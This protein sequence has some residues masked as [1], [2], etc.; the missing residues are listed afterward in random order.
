MI[1]DLVTNFCGEDKC[2]YIKL[3]FFAS[4]HFCEGFIV[5][6]LSNFECSLKGNKMFIHRDNVCLRIFLTNGPILLG[7]DNFHVLY[8]IK[9]FK[10]LWM[11]SKMKHKFSLNLIGKKK[12]FLVCN[13]SW[14]PYVFGDQPSYPN[15]LSSWF[16][17]SIGKI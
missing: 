9:G 11:C 2:F 6:Y 14:S 16:C 10:Q 3:T 7:R 5:V 13:L 17:P 15:I 4:I 1:I 8:Q 12:P